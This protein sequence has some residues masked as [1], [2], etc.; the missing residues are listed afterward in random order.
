MGV[1][2]ERSRPGETHREA[3]P[4][5]Q[6]TTGKTAETH[7]ASTETG[8]NGQAGATAE[9]ATTVEATT[10]GETATTTEAAG[11]TAES[12]GETTPSTTESGHATETSTGAAHSDSGEKLLG[13]K[14][15]STGL[16]VTAIVAS[17]ALALALWLV[18]GSMLLLLGAA[19]VG[20]VFAAFDLHEAT[21]QSDLSD[22]TLVVVALAVSALHLAV[23]VASGF[24]IRLQRRPAQSA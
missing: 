23:T 4:S 12:G 20:V 2:I 6:I 24:G 11:G 10:T 14:T 8:T 5:A 3:S 13:I 15:E 1:A 17:I 21:H 22:T 9:T 18:P 7:A 19:G 16:V